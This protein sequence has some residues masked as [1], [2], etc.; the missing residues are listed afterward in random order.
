MIS[1]SQ[2]RQTRIPLLVAMVFF[3]LSIGAASESL[4]QDIT[5]VADQVACVP[6]G[7]NAAVYATVNNNVPD[8]TV[9]FFFRRLNDVVEDLYFVDMYPS[10]DGRYWGVTPKA[11]KH[12]L[13]RHELEQRREEATDKY[14]QAQW[15]R[16][17][18]N[19]DHRNPNK[20]LD[21]DEIRERASKG[22]VE[23]RE[24]MAKLDDK[25]FDEWLERLD[26][27]PVEYFVAVFGPDGELLARS[28]MMIGEVRKQDRCEIELTPIQRGEAENLV[29]GETADWQIDK[30]VFHW[31][32]AGV[33]ARVGPNGVKRPDPVCRGCVPCFDPTNILNHSYDGAVS[34]SEF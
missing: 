7:D 34:P 3:P 22:K 12:K 8:T 19:T 18:D 21:D 32:C 30:P 5:V 27:E 4:A 28:P 33:V 20:D 24:W 26:F 29:V 25:E 14:L 17:K 23:D 15:W 11:E 6:A 2:S 31:L 10:G 1:I 16:E 9:R 13:D